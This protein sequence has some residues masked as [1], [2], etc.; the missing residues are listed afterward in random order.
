MKKIIY[1]ILSILVGLIIYYISYGFFLN[2]ALK[3]QKFDASQDFNIS[4]KK[5]DITYKSEKYPNI[6]TIYPW[7]FLHS[8][9]EGLFKKD[10][11]GE[12]NQEVLNMILSGKFDGKI[13]YKI[14][15]TSYP[16]EYKYIESW[17][18]KK[19]LN[20][21]FYYNLSPFKVINNIF[22]NE[23]RSICLENIDKPL[24]LKKKLYSTEWF[25]MRGF[26]YTIN[27]SEK[28]KEDWKII[29]DNLL[30][31]GNYPKKAFLVKSDNCTLYNKKDIVREYQVTFRNN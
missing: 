5:T 10:G 4:I 20:T 9:P 3:E 15:A 26:E 12:M 24:S 28:D 30:I 1:I 22:F 16:F 29:L 6:I 25:S 14:T 7:E 18:N 13:E 19:R 31:K 27:M 23:K 11:S 2:L 17:E 21:L 8:T